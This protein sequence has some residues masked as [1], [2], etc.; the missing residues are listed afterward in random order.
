MSW[1]PEIKRNDEP[2]FQSLLRAIEEDVKA[3]KLPSGSRLPTQRELA[4]GLKIAIGTVTRAYDE[5]ERRG[6]IYGDGRRG[7]FVG[8]ALRGRGLLSSMSHIGSGGIDLGKN[9]PAPALDPDLAG[10]LRQIARR[11]DSQSLLQYAPAAGLMRHR[12]AG[13]KWLKTLGMKVAA[14]QVFLC[15]G[16]Q[17]AMMVITAAE[18]RPGDV[19]AA[20]EYT[21]P[22]V[23]EIA[24]VL[25]LDL[26][27]IPMD[28]EGIIPE[29]LETVCRHRTIRL[30][31]CNPS[32][33]NPTSRIFSSGRRR[34]IAELARKYDFMVL[35]DEI[36]SPLL[37]S[38]PDYITGFAPERSYFVASASKSVAAG[39]RLG[40]IVAPE[41]ARQRLIDS[42]QASN[43]GGPAL[44]AEIF[45]LWQNDGVVEK[46]IAR[47]RRELA[48]MHKIT[49]DVL[50]G[51]N[52][53]SN[54]SSYHVW[55]ELPAGWTSGKFSLE[56]QGRGVLVAPGEIF[57]VDRK[58]PSNFA[59]LSI[60]AVS[61]GERLKQALGIIRNILTGSTRGHLA[62]V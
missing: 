62:A 26:T 13:A 39:L 11:S 15:G 6:L 59:R 22:G 19:I 36:L 9:H 34:Q 54:R 50:K 20:E 4:D 52:I 8:E 49:C 5:A 47:R 44:T 53:S 29:A 46:T 16:A 12:E 48:A 61:D 38:P 37:E 60:G 55:L 1:R 32:S 28:A 17:H 45:A 10:T 3:G 56:A 42:L 24:D 2:L 30:L 21:Y 25:G 51:F 27:G 7:T 23:K 14:E 40:F 35:E 43:L 31:Y 58:A 33:Q 41:S 18:T 57:A